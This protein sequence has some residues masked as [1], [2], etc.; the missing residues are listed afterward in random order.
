MTSCP[1]SPAVGAGPTW[2]L[3]RDAARPIGTDRAVSYPQMAT[4]LAGCRHVGGHG[5]FD[6]LAAAA[7]HLKAL[8]ARR[9]LDDRAWDAAR[10]YNGAAI[11]AD[12]VVAWAYDYE[13]A[14]TTPLTP[15]LGDAPFAPTR[16]VPGAYARLQPTGARRRDVPRP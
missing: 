16:Q 11:Y 14:A 1:G 13:Q 2:R 9:I 3:Y 7:A 4:Q 6:A 12:I 5:Y 8:G 15:T 10:A